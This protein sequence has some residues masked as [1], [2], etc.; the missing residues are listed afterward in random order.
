MEFP[1]EKTSLPAILYRLRNKNIDSHDMEDT[2]IDQRE[3]IHL[4]S[5]HV[6][7]LFLLYDCFLGRTGPF[8]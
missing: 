1:G 5:F 2:F 3:Y 6:C 4:G 7:R 8:H